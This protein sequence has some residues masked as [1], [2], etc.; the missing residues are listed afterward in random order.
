M[1]KFSFRFPKWLKFPRWFTWH[2]TPY[3]K[4]NVIKSLAETVLYVLFFLLCF[5]FYIIWSRVKVHRETVEIECLELPK[6]DSSKVAIAAISKI[7]YQIPMTKT[8]LNGNKEANGFREGLFVDF[9]P[10]YHYLDRDSVWSYN[11]ESVV[12]TVYN[13]NSKFRPLYVGRRIDWDESEKC[14]YRTSYYGDVA[15]LDSLRNFYYE[16]RKEIKK[17]VRPIY[18]IYNSTSLSVRNPFPNVTLDTITP[19]HVPGTFPCIIYEQGFR[20]TRFTRFFS[21]LPYAQSQ[22]SGALNFF[23]TGAYQKPR[24]FD[25]EDITQ[26]YYDF[27]LKSET[28]DSIILKFDFVGAT[29]F[30]LMHPEPDVVTMSSIEFNKPEKIR[31]IKNNGLRFYADFMELHNWQTVRM[32]TVTAIMSAMFTIFLGMFIIGFINAWMKIRGTEPEKEDERPQ[33]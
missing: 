27:K 23:S 9:E 26:R 21:G 6:S 19:K 30:S 28:V 22:A 32:F 20:E 5:Y 14:G 2:R 17:K 18:Y 8:E 33:E 11:Y 7:T 10:L 29:S 3:A 31:E 4:D 25:L 15:M 16:K 12:N 1:T 13:Y 24:W